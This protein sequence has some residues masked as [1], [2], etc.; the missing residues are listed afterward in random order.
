[1]TRRAEWMNQLHQ[2]FDY[3]LF[4]VP[5]TIMQQPRVDIENTKDDWASY[6]DWPLPSSKSVDVFLQGD[7]AATPGLLG[8][9]S[10]GATDTLRWTDLSNQSEA[11]ALNIAAG[12][13]QTNRRV[14]LSPPLKTDLR[15][16]GTPFIDLRASL[17]KPQSNLSAM[18]VDYGPSTQ[19][20][21]SADGIQTPANAP[22]DCWG[23]SST[24]VGPNGQVMDY[25]AC[26][27]QPIKPTVNVTATQGWRISRGILDSSNRDSLY[28]DVPVTPGAEYRFRYPILPVDYTIPA[29]HRMGVVLMANFSNLERN[30]TTGTTITMNSRAS[31]ISLPVVGGY[32]A[33]VAAGAL[34]ADTVAPVF[35]TTPA[36]IDQTT[37]DTTGA[38][39][40]FA[41]PT[42][43]DDEDPS[44]AVSCDHAPGS[45]FSVGSTLVTCTATDASGNRAQT[46]FT[47]LLRGSQAVGATVPAT[48]SLTLGGAASFGAFTPGVGKDYTAQTT[49]NVLSTA[50]DAAL[51]VSDPGHLMNGTFALPRAL[52]VELSKASWTAPVSN[53][54]VT[55][56]FKQRIDA[57][58]AVRTGTYSKTLTFTLSTTTP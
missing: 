13:T 24:R 9:K 7:T 42:A 27:Q 1:M 15:V 48:L 54:P 33:L 18:L 55:I 19:I 35:T 26:Y 25:D 47:V 22:S 10:G 2:W 34:E 5:N 12:T 17:D 21:R 11:T 41:L 40:S 32:G 39:I 43:T 53:D 45:K 50:G 36:N 51:S 44:P 29:G 58:D 28:A 14:F 31:R 57:T 3:W 8:G 52:V 20:T 46:T 56:T 6:A 38:A 37:S 49:A 16:S 23:S 30:G 4:G